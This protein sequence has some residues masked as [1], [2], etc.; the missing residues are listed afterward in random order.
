MPGSPFSEL[1][2]HYEGLDAL[3]LGENTLLIELNRS[4]EAVAA[5]P[6]GDMR[7]ERLLIVIDPCFGEIGLQSSCDGPKY[8]GRRCADPYHRRV[9]R[10]R[11]SAQPRKNNSERTDSRYRRPDAFLDDAYL[12]FVDIADEAQR[13][14]RLR[15]RPRATRLQLSADFIELRA[16][17]Y[18]D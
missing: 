11:E 10:I 6:Y 1:A 16:F 12:G 13:D 7:L 2:L 15:G 14:M 3:E 5:S 4:A 18:R 17:W 8:I 9:L